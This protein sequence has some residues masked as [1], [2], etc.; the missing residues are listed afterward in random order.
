MHA[1]R[2][3]RAFK[4]RRS[5]CSEPCDEPSHPL[6]VEAA[7]HRC[8]V[9]DLRCDERLAKVALR[10]LLEYDESEYTLA[11]W[12]D[13]ANYLTRSERCFESA[14]QVK[15]YISAWLNAR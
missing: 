3:K 1:I 9:S 12:A 14:A 13:A 11:Q 2:G 10:E 15:R 8:L 6:D 4:A 5:T 7:A